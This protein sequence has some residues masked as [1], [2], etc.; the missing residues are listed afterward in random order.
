MSI[1]RL[2]EFFCLF[3]GVVGGGGG[4]ELFAFCFR[5][6]SKVD[7]VGTWAAIVLRFGDE[8]DEIGEIFRLEDRRF[9][10]AETFETPCLFTTNA[11]RE[12]YKR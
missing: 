8:F 2:S 4:V 11:L 9:S 7:V 1:E 12:V 3:F 10:F 6:D 5:G